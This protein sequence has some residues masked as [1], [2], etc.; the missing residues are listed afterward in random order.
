MLEIA[1]R[2]SNINLISKWD[3]AIVGLARA[4]N[5]RVVKAMEDVV[6]VGVTA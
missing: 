1:R 5:L 3:V 6:L 4:G 2:L